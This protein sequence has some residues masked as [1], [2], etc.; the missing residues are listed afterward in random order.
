[1]EKC[2]ISETP[3]PDLRFLNSIIRII[4]SFVTKP[5]IHNEVNHVI[6][7]DIVSKLE[8]KFR[9]PKYSKRRK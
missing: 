8:K 4:I 9:F 3:I 6:G 7:A 1:M 5:R 2:H